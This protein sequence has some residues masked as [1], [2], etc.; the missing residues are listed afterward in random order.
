MLPYRAAA[1]ALLLLA[2]GGDD[3]G[4]D[5][6]PAD[7]ALGADASEVL[8]DAGPA[9]LCGEDKDIILCDTA[10]EICVEVE[11]G[12]GITYECVPVPVGCT[13]PRSCAT[14]AAACEEPADECADTDAENTL[15][16][17]CLECG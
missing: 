8:P 10:T 17:A 11:L 12:A 13:E 16:C 15:S 7:A 2:C 14:C 3:D 6:P 5:D 4:S 1:L 9:T